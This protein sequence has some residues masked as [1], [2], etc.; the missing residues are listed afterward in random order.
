M[1]DLNVVAVITA[2]SG[3]ESEVREALTELVTATRTEAGCRS[4]ELFE[5]ASA[6][7]TFVTIERFE[8]QAAM[9]AHM[10]SDHIAAAFAAAGEHLAEA[11]AI[12]VLTPVTP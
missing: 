9:D 4:Y 3:S 6:P 8:D 7:G 2:T 11:P 1:S 12:H 5:S 10:Q